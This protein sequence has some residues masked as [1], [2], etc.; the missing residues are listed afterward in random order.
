MTLPLPKPLSTISL[1]AMIFG[2]LMIVGAFLG[3][4]MMFVMLRSKPELLNDVLISTFFP[5]LFAGQFLIAT[6]LAAGGFALRNGKMWGLAAIQGVVFVFMLVSLVV[7]VIPAAL[8]VYPTSSGERSS[9]VST[10][11]IVFSMI[12]FLVFSAIEYAL[13]RFL[14]Y[15]RGPKV[16]GALLSHTLANSTN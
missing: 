11:F 6:I 10:A 5:R 2:A 4:T 1:V 8:L 9:E 7:S 14:L 3:G 16:K 12:F 13:G 15:L